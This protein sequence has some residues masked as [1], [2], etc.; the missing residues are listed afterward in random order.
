MNTQIV[1]CDDRNQNWLIKGAS[2]ITMDPAL[3]ELATADIL[4]REG[5]IVD[6]APVIDCPDVPVIDARDF[7]AIPG[8]VDTH[9][10]L[11][12]GLIRNT[13]P[14]GTLGDYFHVANGAFG[15]IYTP[16]DVYA[17]TLLSA[18]G[19]LDA[20]VTTVLDWAH[21]Q[22]SP[23]HTEASLAALHEAGGRAVF[24]FGPP[25]NE[26]IGHRYPEDI[27]R[28]R[29]DHFASDDQLLTL[30]LAAVSPE[31]IAPEVAKRNWSKAR[32]AGVRISTHAGIAG[33]GSP[34]EI[35][36]FGRAGLLG[37]DVTLIHCATL[38]ET[39]WKIVADTG[40]TI[41][42]STPIELLMGHGMP[43][44]Q[45]ALDAGIEPS[46]S[47]DVETSMPGDFFTQ[48]RATLT[49]QRGLSFA[50]EH[51]GE[52]APERMTVRDVLRYATVAGAHT[53]GLSGRVGRIA[54][55]LQA[56]IVLLRADTI[57]T[58]PVNDLVG[59]VVL[60]MDLSNVDTVMV[61]GRIV[62]RDGRLLGVNM[63]KLRTTVYEAR[64]RIFGKT[65]MRCFCKQ[66]AGGFV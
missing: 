15:P 14:D 50:R 36:R 64:D 54:R 62:K 23:D 5:V 66:H 38:S 31:H 46:L 2:V 43:P 42:I 12:E 13:L 24:A 17:G 57:N 11:W 44:L 9:R 20:G 49:L 26:S 27:L 45:Q 39:E 51:A 18:L 32:E 29:R 59:A 21:V 30:A 19:A 22:N 1:A 53:N 60:G 35:E 8:F 33:K 52:A 65:G 34:D 41:S 61:A 3:G 55:G 28:L 63:E 58:M 16:D 37:P 7:I 56:D 40:T 4:V 25:T 47:V 48:M 10:H 6:V